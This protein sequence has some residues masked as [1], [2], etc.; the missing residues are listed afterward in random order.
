MKKPSLPNS[1]AKAHFPSTE[2][3]RTVTSVETLHSPDTSSEASGPD[4]FGI[5]NLSYISYII[6]YLIRTAAAPHNQT[7][8]DVCPE[9]QLFPQTGIDKGH[10]SG[11]H[12]SSGLPWLQSFEHF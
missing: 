5:Q 7:G 8:Q 11:L 2:T 6:W 4:V 10:N 1:V 3:S 9:M 12:R